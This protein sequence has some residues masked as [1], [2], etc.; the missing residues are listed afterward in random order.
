MKGYAEQFVAIE[1]DFIAA[2]HK[3]LSIITDEASELIAQGADASVLAVALA[4]ACAEG[5][6]RD[7]A[8]AVALIEQLLL[9]VECAT[10]P[11]HV[12]FREAA[13]QMIKTIIVQEKKKFDA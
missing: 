6:G 10:K 9:I 3:T 1:L 4:Q 5:A 13:K 7:P 2:R 8:D 11:A 12:M